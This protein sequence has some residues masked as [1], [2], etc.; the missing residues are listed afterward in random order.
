MSRPLSFVSFAHHL[1]L[2]AIKAIPY[3]FVSELF[4]Q[5]GNGDDKYKADNG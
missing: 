1:N 3:N 2:S 5:Q 4:A